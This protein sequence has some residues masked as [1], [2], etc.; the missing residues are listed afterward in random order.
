MT[1]Y[2]DAIVHEWDRMDSDRPMPLLVRKRIIGAQAMISHVT[3][4]A[5]LVVPT[6][7]H[8][9]EQ[10]VCILSGR[11]RF[12]IGEQDDPER[13]EF[14]LKGGQVLQLPSNVPHSCEVLER[15]VVLDIFSPPSEKTGIDASTEQ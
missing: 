5:G 14:V 4:E 11:A 8:V 9:N 3:L 15:T 6:H 13:Q 12:G 1:E 10:F 2:N 7:H